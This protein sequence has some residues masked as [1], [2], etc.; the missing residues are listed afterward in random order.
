MGAGLVRTLFVSQ[1]LAIRSARTTWTVAQSCPRGLL[2]E[3]GEK[4][5]DLRPRL[6]LPR[7]PRQRHRLPLRKR[8]VVTEGRKRPKT[9][10]HV[11]PRDKTASCLPKAVRCEYLPKDRETVPWGTTSNKVTQP[12]SAISIRRAPTDRPLADTPVAVRRVPIYMLYIVMGLFEDFKPYAD[13]VADTARW[14]ARKGWA[15]AT[16]TNYSVRLPA[17]AAPAICAITAS[18]IDKD[19]L[20][21]DSIIAI[22]GKGRP[23]NGNRLRPSA[24]TPLH[25]MLYRR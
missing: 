2:A 3:T 19:H 7:R 11:W 25:L 1:C 17:D 23:M 6:W 21:S 16:S 5:Q 15:P 9:S 24:E 10:R 12:H 8:R 22:D 14:A 13:Q 18:G 4:P 20:G